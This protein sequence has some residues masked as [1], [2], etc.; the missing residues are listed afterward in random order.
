MERSL[1][2][3][4]QTGFKV[5]LKA[6]EEFGNCELGDWLAG[7]PQ[8]RNRA[9]RSMWDVRYGIGHRAWGIGKMAASSGQREGKRYP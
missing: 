1:F 4:E 7:K 9:N 6:I 3:L 5:N 2:Y 8:I